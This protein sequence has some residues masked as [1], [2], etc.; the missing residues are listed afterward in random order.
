MQ[1]AITRPYF[2][3]NSAPNEVNVNVHDFGSG[4]A[5]S[6]VRTPRPAGVQWDNPTKAVF[7]S[8]SPRDFSFRRTT[9][10]ATTSW[11]GAIPPSGP[12]RR[13]NSG[14]YEED[15]APISTIQNLNTKSN[16]NLSRQISVGPCLILRDRQL[17]AGVALLP[18]SA[19]PCRILIWA[20]VPDPGDLVGGGDQADRETHPSERVLWDAED[21]GCAGPRG[22]ISRPTGYNGRNLGSLEDS[23]KFPRKNNLSRIEPSSDSRPILTKR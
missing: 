21:L 8:K 10:A 23:R 1:D 3:T 6:G 2:Q 16:R 11:R 17:H 14:H 18:G 19:R 22:P 7:L 15:G 5:L 12:L 4:G 9:H 13:E 20:S